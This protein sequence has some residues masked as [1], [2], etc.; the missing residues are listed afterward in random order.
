MKNRLI[1]WIA[2]KH[3]LKGDIFTTALDIVNENDMEV[4]CGFTENQWAK[5]D[6][7]LGVGISIYNKITEI[8]SAK[9]FISHF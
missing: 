6:G 4:L 5:L 9:G 3:S 1:E 7:P 8:K 2:E